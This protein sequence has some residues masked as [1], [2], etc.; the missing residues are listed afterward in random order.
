MPLLISEL[1][2]AIKLL[3][4]SSR[5]KGGLFVPYQHLYSPP[6][7]APSNWYSWGFPILNLSCASPHCLGH[8]SK[9]VWIPKRQWLLDCLLLNIKSIDLFL[10]F[11]GQLYRF[12]KEKST[13]RKGAQEGQTKALRTK[14]RLHVAGWSQMDARCPPKLLYHCPPQLGRG[15]KI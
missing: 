14:C 6:A 7:Q 5:R 11:N 3:P 15:Q 10:F 4:F 12:W 1:G 13:K 9:R 2:A 8:R